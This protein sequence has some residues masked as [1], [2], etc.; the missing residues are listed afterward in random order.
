MNKENLISYILI[1]VLS[2]AF[3]F[4][5]FVFFITKNKKMLSYKL[6]TGAAIIGLTAISATHQAC[7]TCYD[8]AEPSNSMS[9]DTQLPDS[10]ILNLN[11]TNILKG[12][13]DN[14]EGSNFSFA[15]TDTSSIIQSGQIYP[16]DGTFDEYSENFEIAVDNTLHDGNYSLKLYSGRSSGENYKA[17]YSLNV[18]RK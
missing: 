14:C 18:I 12:Q 13:I 16:T 9:V 7:V 1:A 10:V 3:I 4:V 6:K 2:I 11:S 8:D 17:I 15:I 5:A